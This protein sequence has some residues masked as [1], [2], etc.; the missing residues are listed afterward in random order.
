MKNIKYIPLLGWL[1]VLILFLLGYKN[2]LGFE[3]HNAFLIATLI[4]F[5]SFGILAII[6]GNYIKTL[7]L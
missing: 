5:I 1:L 7:L 6:L 4:Q 3:N 2:K